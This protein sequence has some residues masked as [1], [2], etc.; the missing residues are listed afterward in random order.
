MEGLS[1]IRLVTFLTP[2]TSLETW[3]TLGIFQREVAL[4]QAFKEYGIQVSLV[5]YG[6]P[7]ELQYAGQIP[8]I[9][10]LCNRWRLPSKWYAHLLPVL[11]GSRLIR[12]NVYKTNQTKGAEIALRA[13][14]L[15]G[16]PLVA[17]CGFMRS[18]FMARQ[19]GEDSGAAR[20]VRRIE[21]R[22]FG[23]AK[24]VIV[25]TEDMRRGIAKRFP[26]VEERTVVVP[27]YVDTERFV[28]RG[29]SRNDRQ[30]IFI[31]RME[32][33]KNLK[34]LLEAIQPLDIT[35]T[36]VGTGSLRTELED[37][38][39]SVNGRIDWLGSV[40]HP[41]LP[42]LLNRAA[43]FV[44][45][46]H[47]EGHPK[48]L[49]EAMA[50]GLPVI[51]GDSPGIREIIQHGENGWLCGTDSQS[52]RTAIRELLERPRLRSELGR[53]ARRYVLERFS[54]ERIVGMELAVL[55]G[56]ITR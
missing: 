6:G 25:T 39:E 9:E 54:L 29:E 45:P 53:N 18:E 11:H 8:G 46:S 30:I 16:K 44:L 43:L 4:Y 27:N 38:F 3:D 56:A 1:T 33:Q 23:S 26:G 20:E 31:G 32:P 2:G 22:V 5:T 13:S 12:A 51:G 36:L 50:C 41:T 7:A 15:W 34:A 42:A 52:I 40:P 47:Y 35:L 48:A 55:Q 37:R 49:L 10:V 24:A 21:S 17:R 19:H 28:P 14:R